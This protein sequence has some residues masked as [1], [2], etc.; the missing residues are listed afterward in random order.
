MIRTRVLRQW[1]WRWIVA[2]ASAPVL[3]ASVVVGIAYG[4][5]GWYAVN[6]MLRR[7]ANVWGDVS[8]DDHRLS[9]GI[10]LSL[11]G[12]R[13]PDAPEPV[14]WHQ[15][16]TGLEVAELPVRVGGQSVD[17]L[18]LS[19]ID[20][21]RYRFRVLNRPAGDRDVGDWM[22][23]TGA[24]LVVNGSYYGRHGTPDTPVV[25]DGHRLGPASYQAT[26]GAFVVGGPG[27]QGGARLVDLAGLDWR[28]AIGGTSQAMVSYPML[29]GA[30]GHGRAGGTDERWLANRSFLGQ[31]GAGRII[32]GTTR[33]AYFSLPSLAA[34][35]PR[36]GLDLRLALNLDGGPVACQ[37]VSAGGYRRDFCGRYE[38]AVHG[39]RLQLLWPLVDFRRSALPMALVAVPR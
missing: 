8:P 10:R 20:T 31:D 9:R 16:A 5:G 17:A 14:R 11:A 38:L 24:S 25:S 21:A 1:R 18:L 2:L 36:T 37:K 15:V 30:D 26:H 12:Q 3:V 13:T 27:G 7:G 33:D 39:G 28:Q 34:F 29:L 6:V 22:K 35:L 19:R 23:A 32:V 4:K